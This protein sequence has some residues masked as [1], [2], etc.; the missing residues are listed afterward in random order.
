M[1]IWKT[2]KQNMSVSVISAAIL[3]NSSHG[4]ELVCGQRSP[5]GPAIR[6]QRHG[7][8]KLQAHPSRETAVI[9]AAPQAGPREVPAVPAQGFYQKHQE[10][11]Q[12]AEDRSTQKSVVVFVSLACSG[13]S[14][15]T[16]SLGLQR[17][18]QDHFYHVL[19]SPSPL[20]PPPPHHPHKLR[21]IRTGAGVIPQLD[22][23]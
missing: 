19:R 18:R 10:Q 5:D 14:K 1:I 4:K 17:L 8:Q 6:S 12:K 20:Q 23:R 11:N 16:L 22:V 21:G 9:Q 2:H 3:F 7:R 15:P 13:T